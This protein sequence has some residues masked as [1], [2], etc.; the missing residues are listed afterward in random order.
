MN[1]L[2][3]CASDRTDGKALW[4]LLGR[5]VVACCR[6]LLDDLDLTIESSRTTFNQRNIRSQAHLIHMSP[7]IQVIQRIKHHGET[8]E[9]VDIELRILDVCMVSLELH[10]WVELVRRFL[11]HLCPQLSVYVFLSYSH[12]TNQSLRFLDMLVPEEELPV[13]VAQ[14]DGVEVNNMDF[15]EAREDQILE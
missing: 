2:A 5:A 11:S 15:A 9:P 14:I 10:I 7:C 13:E 8:L 1:R 6:T 3:G 4:C 12:L